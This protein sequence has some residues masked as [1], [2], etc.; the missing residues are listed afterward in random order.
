MGS[1]LSEGTQ[2]AVHLGHWAHGACSCG[3]KSK[4][5]LWCHIFVFSFTAI[6]RGFWLVGPLATRSR[7]MVLPVTEA[8]TAAM[9]LEM[10][11]WLCTVVLSFS[12]Y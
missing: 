8:E 1:Q 5:L 12:A 3:L 7:V 11:E 2:Y 9:V 10:P 6:L 4:T